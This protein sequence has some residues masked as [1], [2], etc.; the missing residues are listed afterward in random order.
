MEMKKTEKVSNHIRSE[1][2]GVKLTL[3]KY[4]QRPIIIGRRN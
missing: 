2:N 1:K 3:E 4:D